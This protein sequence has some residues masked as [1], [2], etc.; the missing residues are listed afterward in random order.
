M[1]V[2]TPLRLHPFARAPGMRGSADIGKRARCEGWRLHTEEEQEED[3]FPGRSARGRRKKEGEQGRRGAEEAW[4][5]E[6][7]AQRKENQSNTPLK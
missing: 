7:E 6:P 1:A 3:L 4:V 2:W 5:E